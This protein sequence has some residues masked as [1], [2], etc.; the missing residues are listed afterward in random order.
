MKAIAQLLLLSALLFSCDTKKDASPTLIS[1]GTSFG[2]CAGYCVRSIEIS[3][4]KL[5]YRASSWND[6]THP[7][8][9]Y[10]SKLSAA[11]WSELIALVDIETLQSY[12]DVIGCPDCADGGAEWVKVETAD[13]SKQ[14]T[15][16]YGDSLSTIQPLIDHLR[17]FRAYFEEQLFNK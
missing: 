3:S 6:P 9:D 11:E 13:G 14:I 17:I 4:G 2:E 7:T 10:D 1:S 16:E 5:L 15:F 8:V 12:P